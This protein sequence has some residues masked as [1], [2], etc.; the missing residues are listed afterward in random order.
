MS[1]AI[2]HQIAAL[3]VTLG[4]APKVVI[5]VFDLF[6]RPGENSSRSDLFASQGVIV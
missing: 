5:V 4:S 6:I 1:T 2:N 3:I